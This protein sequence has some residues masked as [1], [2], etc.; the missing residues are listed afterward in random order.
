[1]IRWLIKTSAETDYLISSKKFNFL[2]SPP[3]CFYNMFKVLLTSIGRIEIGLMAKVYKINRLYN[4]CNVFLNKRQLSTVW[5][6]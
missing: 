3:L 6:I 2:Q 5:K 1:M 4:I